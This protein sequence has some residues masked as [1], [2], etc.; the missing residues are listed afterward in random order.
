MVTNK[1]YLIKAL[2]RRPLKNQRMKIALRSTATREANQ[3]CNDYSFYHIHAGLRHPSYF[4]MEYGPGPTEYQMTS[5]HSPAT[6][7]TIA[8]S[9]VNI[10]SIVMGIKYIYAVSTVINAQTG[11]NP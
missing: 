5:K 8:S 7:Y 9:S 3:P 2:P 1:A 10:V 4:S 11:L 6:L